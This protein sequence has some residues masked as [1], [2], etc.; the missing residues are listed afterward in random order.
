MEKQDDEKRTVIWEFKDN[1]LD[2]ILSKITIIGD[3]DNDNPVIELSFG[4]IVFI[5]RIKEFVG[6]YDKPFSNN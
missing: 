1:S 3:T 4:G 5:K 6:I 2:M